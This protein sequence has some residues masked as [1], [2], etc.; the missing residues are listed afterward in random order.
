MNMAIWEKVK[1][2]KRT[3]RAYRAYCWQMFPEFADSRGFFT[4]LW[5]YVRRQRMQF[6]PSSQASFYTGPEKRHQVLLLVH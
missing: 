4:Q 3:V 6:V 1:R 5:V 2:W